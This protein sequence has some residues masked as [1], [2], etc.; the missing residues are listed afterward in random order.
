[1]SYDPTTYQT[2]HRNG[3]G[4]TSNTLDTFSLSPV[5]TIASVAKRL[6][7]REKPVQLP[8]GYSLETLDQI[9]WL[10]GS[11]G[12]EVHI[13][14]RQATEI[15]I[16]GRQLLEHYQNELSPLERSAINWLLHVV[17]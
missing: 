8:E 15:A 7:I 2:F 16:I 13:S 12:Q 14:A 9:T 11:Y 10:T 17:Q 1:M 5:Y 3:D 4:Y 6:L